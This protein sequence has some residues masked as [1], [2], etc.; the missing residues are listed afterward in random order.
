MKSC[1][2]LH[3]CTS[4]RANF[5][6]LLS[7]LFGYFS[8]FLLLSFALPHGIVCYFLLSP[9]SSP[10]SIKF[11]PLCSTILSSFDPLF[12]D[13]PLRSPSPHVCLLILVLCRY[14]SL[15][16]DQ[17]LRSFVDIAN[18]NK[19]F[20]DYSRKG[21]MWHSLASSVGDREGYSR[22]PSPSPRVCTDVRSLV[23]WRHYQIFSAWWVTNIAYPWCFASALRALRLR[24][25]EHWVLSCRIQSLALGSALF[26]IQRRD[27]FSWFAAVRVGLRILLTIEDEQEIVCLQEVNR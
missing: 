14:L 16:V 18:R 1:D 24:Y 19:C 26:Y 12:W 4:Q 8:S 6:S 3:G 22:R 7:Q 20:S 15:S 13:G 5:S 10:D 27:I 21:K 17:P 9:F 25:N 23:R 2:F 11:T